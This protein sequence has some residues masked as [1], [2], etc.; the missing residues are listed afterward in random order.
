MFAIPKVVHFHPQITG[1]FCPQIDTSDNQLDPADYGLT[2]DPFGAN[3]KGPRWINIWD[4]DDP[5]A[6]PVEPLM[7]GDDAVVKDEYVDLS[8][9]VSQAHGLYWESE[10]VHRSIGAAW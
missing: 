3:L 6:W 4:R 2:A 1:T 7:Q 9:L 8:D 5:I 10:K